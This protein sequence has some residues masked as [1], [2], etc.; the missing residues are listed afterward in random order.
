MNHF[1]AP[2]PKTLP[3]HPL[4]SNVRLIGARPHKL[5]HLLQLRI[6]IGADEA[7]VPSKIRAMLPA[8]EKAV[9]A[10]DVFGVDGVTHCGVDL[11]EPLVSPGVWTER[12]S[13]ALGIGGCA[14]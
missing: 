3:I 7:R 10:A 5:S 11:G 9:V 8:Q 6:D 1:P 12:V 14:V 2:A 13:F 4:I